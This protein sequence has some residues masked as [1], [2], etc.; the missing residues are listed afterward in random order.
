M[1]PLFGRIS[2]ALP[3]AMLALGA[4]SL[5]AQTV[6]TPA[7]PAGWVFYDGAGPG[8]DPATITGAQPFNGN[9]SAQF[10]ITASNQQPSALFLFNTPV[11]LSSLG[12]L[13]LGFSWLTPTGT[14]PDASPTIRLLLSGL[15]NTTQVGRSDGSLGW[16]SNTPDGSW[17]TG[18]F[19]LSSGDFFFRVGGVG[20]EADACNAT[21][22]SFDDRRQTIADWVS[23]C[24]GTGGTANIDNATVVGIQVDWG[25]F[26]AAGS[27]TAYADGVTF[28]V[29]ANTGSYN[30]ETAGSLQSVTPEPATLSLMGLG[31][32]GLAG[33]RR[34]R[35]R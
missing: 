18:L 34:K 8:T 12:S 11:T 27:P 23:T 21:A 25:T 3:L 10:T 9:G 29:G 7:A 20:Q 16:Y 26:T 13:S 6:V 14:V 28:T 15:S 1:T 22:L 4:R 5:T 24:N 35:A 17:D 31:L 2:R 33:M 30:F 19:S 32:V